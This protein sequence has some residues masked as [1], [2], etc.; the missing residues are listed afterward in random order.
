[1]KK[2][3]FPF[4]L[5]STLSVNL[6]PQWKLFISPIR[7]T[8][9][10]TIKYKKESKLYACRRL[11]ETYAVKFPERAERLTN[12]SG[13]FPER[14]FQMSAFR[15]KTESIKTIVWRRKHNLPLK[16][17][18]Q[19]SEVSPTCR[20]CGQ[21]NETMTHLFEDCPHPESLRARSRASQQLY[22][23]AQIDGRTWEEIVTRTADS[24]VT[25]VLEKVIHDFVH[26]LLNEWDKLRSKNYSLI[27]KFWCKGEWLLLE[28][29]VLG[30][31]LWK[32]PWLQKISA[33]T[34]IMWELEKAWIRNRVLG[35]RSFGIYTWTL[36]EH[37]HKTN[38]ED[39]WECKL[40]NQAK[41]PQLCRSFLKLW[42]VSN[43]RDTSR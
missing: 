7:A 8:F 31:N 2:T 28:I 24:A 18:S 1:M 30:W 11:W 16:Q 20:R 34:Y 32:W 23:E 42:L 26:T 29:M 41:L 39:S 43:T 37:R 38:S 6:I 40:V 19:E 35:E 33:Q 5:C 3:N 12:S 4:Q 9:W 17:N 14:L 22:E 21:S 10:S 15:A 13:R 25:S 27:Q 36:G